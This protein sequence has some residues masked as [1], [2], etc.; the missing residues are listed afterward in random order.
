MKTRFKCRP[1]KERLA[2][3]VAADALWRLNNGKLSTRARDSSVWG[4]VVLLRNSATVNHT[5]VDTK[6]QVAH[7]QVCALGA[8]FVARALQSDKDWNR[9][10]NSRCHGDLTATSRS[11]IDAELRDIFYPGTLDQIERAYELWA[12]WAEDAIDSKRRACSYHLLDPRDRLKV[13]LRN[14]IAN[15]GDFVIN[16][17]E[18]NEI[19]VKL[20]R[21]KVKVVRKALKQKAVRRG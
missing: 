10:L 17:S 11:K 16:P 9:C 20:H 1:G 21:G 18:Y 3:R 19:T 6:Q 15:H 4:Y 2:V 14:I 12:G 8:M 7:C 13:I 5:L